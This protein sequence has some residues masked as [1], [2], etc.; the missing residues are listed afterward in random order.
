MIHAFAPPL[1]F[2]ALIGACLVIARR[3][4]AEGLRRAALLTRIVAAVCFVLSVPV[5]PGFSI[6]LFIAVSLGFAWVAAYAI[7]LF[8]SAP[9]RDYS[10][11]RRPRELMSISHR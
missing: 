6:R 3:F 7:Y 5:G 9:R 11:A 1:S 8:T 2:L 10:P 4:A